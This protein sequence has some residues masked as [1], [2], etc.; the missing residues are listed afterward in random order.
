MKVNATN[1]QEYNLSS[2]QNITNK[3]QHTVNK[4]K[5]LDLAN[6][7][8]D[9]SQNNSLS[10]SISVSEESKSMFDK[11]N[12][13]NEEG[14]EKKFY[15]ERPNDSEITG[16]LQG[17]FKREDTNR[18]LDAAYKFDEEKVWSY[19]SM[20]SL[21]NEYKIMY[22][23]V[24]SQYT[25]SQLEDQ[26]TILE[27]SY[28]VAVQ[29]IRERVSLAIN[30]Y[31]NTNGTEEVKEML[32]RFIES[33]SFEFELLEEEFSEIANKDSLPIKDEVENI[34]QIIMYYINKSSN[35]AKLN[36]TIGSNT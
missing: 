22:E 3:S 29:D 26:L 33:D 18:L 23:E 5:K 7:N 8:T 35:S 32:S 31:A 2:Q 27:N 1:S 28:D 34:I 21:A 19:I 12:N 11:L 9:N 36:M 13:F 20:S 25:G 10:V 16:I 24:N 6:L 14:K 4:D 15:I 17:E 30:Y